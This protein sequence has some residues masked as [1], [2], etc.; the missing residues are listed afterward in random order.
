MN[1]P[2]ERA[3]LPPGVSP[4]LN[5]GLDDDERWR[6]VA[7]VVCAPTFSRSPRL[8]QLLLFVT[9]RSL[10]GRLGDLTEYNIGW[11]VFERT[12]A[13][14]PSSDSIVRTTARLLRTKLKEHFD[15]E[16]REESLTIEIPKGGYAPV[17]RRRRVK[18]VEPVGN[19]RGWK[20]AGRRSRWFTI[21]IVAL[22]VC[23]FPLGYQLGRRRHPL[24]AQNVAPS[25]LSSFL[26][27]GQQP[28][29][30]I[31]GDYG[32]VLRTIT[33]GQLLSVEDYID[34]TS[35]ENN[36]TLV[37]SDAMARLWASFGNGQIVAL[38]DVVVAGEIFRLAGMLQKRV[39]IEHARRISAADLRSGHLILL[40]TPM[41]NPWM[42]LFEEKLNFR[43]QRSPS[44]VPEESR[45][46]FV[47]THPLPGEKS[48]Y[49]AASTT[50]KFGLTYG[51]V[52]KVP[53]LAGTGKVLLICG[54]RYTGA[55]AAGEYAADADAAAKLARQFNVR[56]VGQLPDFEVLLE[57]YSIDA[58]PRYVEVVAVRRHDD[59]LVSR[60][61]SS[62]N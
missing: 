33:T 7:R 13:Y 9:E 4:L 31:T 40:N 6:L 17:F 29:R 38:P 14:D 28:T 50:P 16:G 26:S 18:A 1:Q 59:D 45:L 27:Q 34:Q 62:Q 47:N 25:I 42:T 49:G 15:A 20:G 48:H 32:A 60:E 57:T 46:R 43:Y 2:G 52:A 10:T 11:Q 55:E 3:G 53:N 23:S 37:Y 39:V 35:T 44:T 41:G 51:L 61:F 54:L 58:A 24:L 19:V 12:Q 21:G 36:D 8:R 56:D 5:P 22:V 30:V